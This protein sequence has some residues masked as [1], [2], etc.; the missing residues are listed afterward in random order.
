MKYFNYFKT[1]LFNLK[2]YQKIYIFIKNNKN[3][4]L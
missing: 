2:K 4:E 1:L 3:D